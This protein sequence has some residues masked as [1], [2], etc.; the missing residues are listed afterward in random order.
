[1]VQKE[2][3]RT[4]STKHSTGEFMLQGRESV[5]YVEGCWGFP[6]MEIK[7]SKTVVSFCFLFLCIT[8]LFFDFY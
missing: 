5:L 8:F 7:S 4:P 1:M 2:E 6:Y 3:F